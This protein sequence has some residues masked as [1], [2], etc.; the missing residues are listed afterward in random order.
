MEPIDRKF[1]FL[2][3]NPCKARDAIYTDKDGFIFLAKDKYC[4]TAL[5]AYLGALR[6]DVLVSEAQVKGVE[7]LIERVRNYQELYGM[8][9]PDVNGYSEIEVVTKSNE[10]R[11]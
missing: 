6:N 9:V 7:L 10:Q 11:R 2:A 8:K 5:N 3:V 4:I 1:K